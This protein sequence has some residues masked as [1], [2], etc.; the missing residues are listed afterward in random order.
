MPLAIDVRNLSRR[1]FMPNSIAYRLRDDRGRSYW[2]DVGGGIGPGSL[3]RTGRLERG[4]LAN[5]RLR[6]R[7]PRGT[8]RVALVFEPSSAS[9]LQV[10]VPLGPVG[11]G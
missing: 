8:R 7:V 10:R 11:R 1:R 2:P 5:M 3:G 4:Q 6:F 9:G